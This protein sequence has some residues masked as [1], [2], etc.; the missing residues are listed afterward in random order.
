MNPAKAGLLVV[1]L[2]CGASLIVA[3]A[4]ASTLSTVAT[5]GRYI[6][7]LMV[8]A[9]LIEFAM[10]SSRLQQAPRSMAKC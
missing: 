8:A 2:L 7:W 3:P 9:H 10:F 6:F 4:E 1:W 5:W